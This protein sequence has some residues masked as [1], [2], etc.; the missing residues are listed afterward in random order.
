MGKTNDWEPV[1]YSSSGLQAGFESAVLLDCGD[2][3]LEKGVE[4][5]LAAVDVLLH[6]RHKLLEVL[7]AN[8][9]LLHQCKK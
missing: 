2:H 3:L 6:T 5:V 4:V 8:Y 7:L 1:T 9:L